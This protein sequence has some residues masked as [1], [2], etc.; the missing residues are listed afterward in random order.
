MELLESA[1]ALLQ[2]FMVQQSFGLMHS[3]EIVIALVQFEDSSYA[4][5]F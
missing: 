2:F 1:D 5:V 3:P 4:N